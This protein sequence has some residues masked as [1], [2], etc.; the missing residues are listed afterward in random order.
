MKVLPLLPS[1][2]ISLEGRERER[3]YNGAFNGTHNSA[4][5]LLPANY[6][7]ECQLKT[8]FR[9]GWAGPLAGESPSGHK[10]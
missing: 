5:D 10:N 4:S 1:S 7:S 2:P 9:K 8:K 3:A 6:V